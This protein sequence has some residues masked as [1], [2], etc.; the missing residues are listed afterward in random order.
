ME[1]FTTGL[2]MGGLGSEGS[3]HNLSV[4][5]T[6]HTREPNLPFRRGV[7]DIVSR[8]G[9]QEFKGDEVV[10]LGV[11]DPDRFRFHVTGVDRRRRDRG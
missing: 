1:S 2:R 10:I 3:F 8:E 4:G 5:K 9:S 7:V 6:F 11:R